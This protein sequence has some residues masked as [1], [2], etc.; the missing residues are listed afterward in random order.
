MF[1]CSNDVRVYHDDE[2]TLPQAERDAMR[3]RR[4]ANRDRL[5]KGLNKAGNP[6]PTEFVGQGSYA[7]R[8]MVCDPDFDY[9]IDDG[10]YFDVDDLVGGRGAELTAL[11]ARWVVRDAVDDGSFERAP[12]VRANCV[13]IFYKKG[14]HVDMPVY[15]TVT[16][17]DQVWHELASSSGWR[18][19][20]AREVT[21]WFDD[22]RAASVDGLQLRRLV[23]MLKAFARSRMSWRGSLL[24][25]FGITV[26]VVEKGWLTA[27]EDV[28]LYDTM[29]AA[30]QRL[31][32]NLVIRHPV[33]AGDTI[34]SGTEDAKARA[35]RDKLAEALRWLEP[36][37]ERNCTRN[38]AL[39]CWDKVFCTTFFSE[40]G[41]GEESKPSSTI[42]TS[43]ALIGLGSS[44]SAAVASSGGGRHA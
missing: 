2:V 10:V 1:D 34:T 35:L 3:D 30:K 4:K 43:A 44:M 5:L 29:K 23:R 16:V 17:G 40:R 24:S 25:G 13:R 21:K 41:N 18:R 32:W 31:D 37:F 42:G 26:L 28:A 39:A 8:T 27:R 14:Y 6:A 20:D 11:Q 33:T 36:L 19:S 15:R 12:E 7:M 22:A 9:D 38:K